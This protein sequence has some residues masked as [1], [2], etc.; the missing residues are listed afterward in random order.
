MPSPS[1]RTHHR[2]RGGA[3]VVGTGRAVVGAVEA[4]RP[5]PAVAGGA[6]VEAVATPGVVGLP[7]R[8]R[9]DQ[10]DRALRRLGRH[11]V[12]HERV[13]PGAGPQLQHVVAGRPARGVD[14][15]GA[16]PRS[17]HCPGLGGLQDRVALQDAAPRARLPHRRAPAAPV[18]TD[19]VGRHAVRRSRR[20]H[21]EPHLRP[22]SAAA[23]RGVGLDP[24]LGR[25]AY[26]PGFRAEGRGRR[27]ALVLTGP[28]ARSGR[29]VSRARGPAVGEPGAGEDA[30]AAPGCWA[31]SSCTPPHAPTSRHVALAATA[32]AILIDPASLAVVALPPLR[33]TIRRRAVPAPEAAVPVL[34]G[35]WMRASRVRDVWQ[36]SGVSYRMGGPDWG[37]RTRP[38][39][40][41]TA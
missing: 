19:P 4:D 35:D 23:D 30:V 32:V 16:A 38:G 31:T 33:G 29:A 1:A 8:D 15:E 20:R 41:T 5:A 21:L 27:T 28:W 34:P 24:S 2:Q 17:D 14:R 13:E 26:P 37:F 39:E 25:P 40:V 36:G 12:R 9:R 3:V 18:R 6:F 22:G 10:C 11:D 7:G